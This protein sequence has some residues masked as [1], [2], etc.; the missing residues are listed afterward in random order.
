[1]PLTR[2][3]A[4]AFELSPQSSFSLRLLLGTFLDF[5]EDRGA[6]IWVWCNDFDCCC[7]GGGRGCWNL[8]DSERLEE[9]ESECDRDCECEWEYVL[10]M[11]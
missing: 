2:R 4:L 5:D 10:D 1:M 7:C 11:A 3:L 6:I 8:G 9:S